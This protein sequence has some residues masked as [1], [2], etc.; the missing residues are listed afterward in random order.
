MFS[1]C[2]RFKFFEIF[3]ESYPQAIIS[4]F[5]VLRLNLSEFKYIASIVISFCSLLFGVADTITF[6]MFGDSFI[7]VVWCMLSLFVDCL[8][9]ALFFSFLSASWV[10][11]EKAGLFAMGLLYVLIIAFYIER[12]DFQNNSYEATFKGALASLVA[13]AWQDN[14]LKECEGGVISI[15]IFNLS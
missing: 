2:F 15:G 4:L 5:I 7:K 14:E 11:P 3:F 8:F 13:S 10:F 6:N 12:K 1:I 9:R